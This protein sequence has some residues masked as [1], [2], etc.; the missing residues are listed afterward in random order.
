MCSGILV[1]AV[2]SRLNR[3]ACKLSASRVIKVSYFE[4]TSLD[5]C[6]TIENDG[7]GDTCFKR[8]LPVSEPG[9]PTIQPSTRRKLEVTDRV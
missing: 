1:A 4:K 3:V 5:C 7:G 2:W 6:E 8:A 9:F